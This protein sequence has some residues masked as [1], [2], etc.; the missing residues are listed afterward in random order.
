[1]STNKCGEE[2]LLKSFLVCICESF[3]GLTNIVPVHLN[4]L[5]LV[6]LLSLTVSWLDHEHSPLLTSTLFSSIIQHLVFQVEKLACMDCYS[7][8]H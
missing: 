5:G 1:M 2:L 6:R 3:S 4:L 8:A 7:P